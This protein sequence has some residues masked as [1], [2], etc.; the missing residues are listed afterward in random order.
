M[1]SRLVLAYAAPPPVVAR[2]LAE[3]DSRQ[4]EAGDWSLAELLEAARDHAAEA[5]VVSGAHKLDAAAIDALPERVR[6]I[7][8][9]TVGFDHIDID[10]ARRR[11]L[12][13]T[14]T[15]DVLTDCTA[16]LCLMLML[17]ACRRATEYAAVMQAGW[18]RRY[19]Q[20]E[21]LGLRFSGRTLGILGMGRIGRAVAQRARGF[22]MDIVYCNRT[23]L[24]EELEQG[25]RHFSD[26]HTMLPHCQILSLHAPA[27]H[28][29]E[30]I[31]DAAAFALLP[32]DAVFVNTARG[33]LVDEDALIDALQT[34]RLFA[35]GL[36]V[37]RNEP[38]F[39]LRLA[40]LPNVFL[41]PHMGSATVETRKAMGFRALDNVAAVLS[42]RRAIDPV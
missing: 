37:F 24:P 15:P 14:N 12:P 4:P 40:S 6:I 42:G 35:A 34:G 11:G 26:F 18:R 23:R 5:V 36:D 28:A 32:P 13:V 8:T 17:A 30:G 20:R 33:S 31:M 1:K 25:A 16:D 7:A 29:T 22:G 21:L 10:A 2:S 3:F 9:A 39:D 41:T 27:G 19:P 38:A